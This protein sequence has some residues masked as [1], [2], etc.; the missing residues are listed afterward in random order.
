MRS[1]QIA[2]G[3][4]IASNP[5]TSGVSALHYGATSG[6]T[7]GTPLFLTTDPPGAVESFPF[8]AFVPEPSSFSLLALGVAALAGRRKL[9]M[10]R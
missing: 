9:R 1:S 5:F 3:S 7:G 2:T 8:V 10:I 4:Q 6:V